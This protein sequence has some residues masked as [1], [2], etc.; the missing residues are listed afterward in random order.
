MKLRHGV[1]AP[2]DDLRPAWLRPSSAACGRRDS[3]SFG[4]DLPEA[5]DLA[6]PVVQQARAERRLGLG[7]MLLDHRLEHAPPSADGRCA[8]RLT[9]SGLTL[10]L[11][12]SSGS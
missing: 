10:S 8:A 2:S 9:V 7:D 11:N 4:H 3:I 6:V 5:L 12:T 1:R